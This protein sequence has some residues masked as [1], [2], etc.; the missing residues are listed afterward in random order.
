[1][2][3]LDFSCPHCN[4][5]LQ[6][7][8]KYRSEK[9]ECP[10][11]GGAIV[12]SN[13]IS[14]SVKEREKSKKEKA[15][16][17]K[18][19]GEIFALACIIVVVLWAIYLSISF[20]KNREP[21]RIFSNAMKF[22]SEAREA[23]TKD[24]QKALCLYK[25]VASKL[26]RLKD[27]YP[28]FQPTRVDAIFKK[29]EVA[30]KIV[31]PDSMFSEAKEFRKKAESTRTDGP[32]ASLRSLSEAIKTLNILK[33]K[34]PNSHTSDV[35]IMLEECKL[36]IPTIESELSEKGYVEF[37]K[38]VWLTRE[39]AKSR[40]ILESWESF[41]SDLIEEIKESENRKNSL[42]DLSVCQCTRRRISIDMLYKTAFFMGSDASSWHFDASI[43]SKGKVDYIKRLLR[44][45]GIDP[46]KN[47]IRIDVAIKVDLPGRVT[48]I[49][50]SH[51][52]P[53]K[54]K[55]D[56]EKRLESGTRDYIVK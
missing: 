45:K 55:I 4:Q 7:D 22:E 43:Y 38:G 36:A 5:E 35:D 23:A 19:F 33:E 17:K 18:V 42:F 16:R 26:K 46:R 10:N 25:G 29:N 48:T 14:S 15:L 34:Y 28:C 40:H 30:V 54:N 31:E 3:Y 9:L 37:K 24:S 39:E 44:E 32:K 20:V 53:Y 2:T 47:H 13:L 50:I 6:V 27:E 41:K 11:C 21:R 51:Y 8:P 1:M 52:D 49:G 12:T 56:Y